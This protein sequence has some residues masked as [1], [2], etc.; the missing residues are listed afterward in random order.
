VNGHVV[1]ER[2]RMW[3]CATALQAVMGSNLSGT[4]KLVLLALFSFCNWRDREKFPC[5]SVAALARRAELSD[6]QAQ[7]VLASLR[8]LGLI[9]CH[10]RYN[11]PSAYEIHLHKLG[12]EDAE[13]ERFRT[14]VTP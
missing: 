1:G 4:K 6:R 3:R 11:A 13:A 12:R 7:R 9:T 5:P 2:Q 10:R 14:P 8:A